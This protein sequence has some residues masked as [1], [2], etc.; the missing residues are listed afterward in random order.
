MVGASIWPSVEAS[1]VSP[2][3]VNPGDW[4][5]LGHDPHRSNATEQQVDPP[6]C[7]S[8]KWY[9]V[10]IASRIQPVVASGQLFIGSMNGLMYARDAT[11]GAPLWTYT[12][13]GPIRSTAGIS[14]DRLIFSSYDGF[15]YALATEDG[16]L[17]W[18]VNTG[19]SVTAPL[20]DESRGWV[21]VASSNGTLTALRL[22]D[23]Q[24]QWQSD[25]GAPI[26]TSP[27]LS[28]DGSTILTGNE[29]MYAL[30]Y[31]A[32][33]GSEL[34]RTPLSGQS[35]A[36]RYPVVAGSIVLYRS[37]PIG[38]FSE[39]LYEGDD[40]LD[41]AGAVDPNW[42]ADWNKVRPEILQ[43]LSSEPIKQ[44][45]FALDL[46][47]GHPA[48]LLPVLYTYGN[49][50]APSVP[51]VHADEVFLAY[52]PRHGIQTDGGS[53]HVS[54]RYDAELGWLNLSTMDIVG[55]TSAPSSTYHNQFRLTSDE[56]SML[57]MGGDILYVDNWERLGGI[58][59]ESGE[60]L[61]VGGV[62]DD[63]P[64]CGAQCGPGTTNPFFP[65]SGNP[66]D[67]A[68]PFPSMRVTEGDQR[69]GVVIANNMLYWRVIE[70]GLAG[71]SHTS[72]GSCSS[73]QVWTA[74][75]GTPSNDPYQPNPTPVE[76][77]ALED[78]LSIDMSVPA[79]N[80]PADLVARLQAEIRDMIQGD[81]HLLP[82][83]LMR[84]FSES[85]I[86]PYNTTNPPG[87]PK[88]T[89]L[90]HGNT[91]WQDPGE[92][93]YTMALAYPY[94]DSSLQSDLR[95]YMSGEMNRYPPL[96]NLSWYDLPWLKVGLPREYY[97]V[98]FRDELANWPP[99]DTNLS[100]LYSLWLWSK[101]TGD[102]SYVEA[103][104][105]Q[106]KALFEARRGSIRYYADLS[107]LIGYTRLAQQLGHTAEYQD[108]RQAALSAMQDAANY[109]LYQ[110]RAA[111]DYPDPRN[112]ETGWSLPELFGLTPEV[113]AFLRE[114]TDGKAATHIL[115]RENGNGVRWWYL[116]RAGDQAEVGET[117]YL[118]PDT[119]WSHFLAHAYVL[120][121]DSATLR[122][123]LDRSWALGDLYFIQK[124]VATI[125]VGGTTIE[126]GNGGK[127]HDLDLPAQSVAHYGRFDAHFQVDTPATDL[128][129]PYDDN[130]PAGLASEIGVTVDGLFTRDGWTTTITQP[131]FYDQPYQHDVIGGRDHFIPSGAPYF[132]VRFTPQTAGNWQFRIRVRDAE[133]VT[134]YPLQ[135]EAG[136]PFT[137]TASN[138]NPYLSRGFLNVSPTDSRYFEF[139]DGRL[140]SGVGFNDG[141]EQSADVENR[142]QAYEE[143]G[144]NFLRVW[145]SGD[146]INGSQWSS[147]A[148]HHLPNDNYLPGVLFDTN[149]TYNG[150]DVSLRID[151]SNPCYFSDF[152]QGGIPVA[153]STDY[154]VWARIKV[155][156]VTGP[157]TSGA[158]G[159]TIKQ[160]QWLGTDCDKG[161]NGTIITSHVN[162]SSDG[163]ITVEGSYHTGSN[164]AW[165]D[166][167][168]LA[169]E[170][171]TGGVVY[172][173]EVRV[174][175]EG[176]PAQVN[177]L[178]EP[179]ANSH[180][181]FDPMSSAQWD[182]FIESAEKHGVYLKLVIDEK[183][184][185]IRNHIAANGQM[186]SS[187][188]NDNFYA[189]S[190]TKVRWLEEAW[191]RYLIG[192]WGYSPAIH[193]FEYINEGDPYDGNH[194][195]AAN[196]MASFFDAH[197]PSRHMVTTSFWHSFPNIEFWSNPSYA[198]IDYA[199]LHAYIST[200]WGTTA[201]FLSSARLETW[202]ANV[203][204]GEA[205]AHFAGTDNGD[206]DIAPRGMVIQG[207][208]EWIIRYWMS[209]DNFTTNCPYSTTG[210]MQR[211]RWQVDGGNY[212]GGHEGVVPPNQEGKD[213]ICT[214]PAGTYTWTQFS[215]DRDRDGNQ[216]DASFRLILNDNNPHSLMI[217]IENSNGT[218]GDAWI[219]HVEIVNPNGEVVQV[220][221]EFITDRMDY[222]AAWYTAAYSEV[223]GGESPVG[224]RMPLVRG[225]TG[226]DTPDEQEW[227]PELTQDTQGIWLHNAV[228][229]QINAGGMY[230]LYW[231]A[232]ETIKPAFYKH[233]LT[234]Q[235]F[236]ADIP[237]NNGH[238]VRAE[239]ETSNP[240]LRAWGQRDDS[241][242]NMHLWIQNSQ[243]TW[244]R[245]VDGQSIPAVNGQVSIVAV[246][247]GTYQIEWWDTYASS[248]PIVLTET[249][250]A[251]GGTLALDLHSPLSSDIAVK[252]NRLS[253]NSATPTPVSTATPALPTPTATLT[254]TPTATALPS[255]TPTTLPSTATATPF[256]A[257]S[258]ATTVS[259]TTPTTASSS[260][261]ATSGTPTP[262]PS[263]TPTNSQPSP[264]ASGAMQGDL[265]VDDVVDIRDIQLW[266]N[267]FL[268]VETNP[269]LVSRADVNGDGSIN[270]IDVQTISNIILLG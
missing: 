196:A 177:I 201:S 233:F 44:T 190:G 35:L 221:G 15:T 91:Y 106:V 248:N 224:A 63:W 140:F 68:Y 57:S 87:V 144:I 54:T 192:R 127:I 171:A 1:S 50:D 209:A 80:P 49:N 130:P 191:W 222:D 167:L 36:D 70:G 48:G 33:S 52:R 220:I 107:G 122:S 168:Y 232:S 172:I 85:Q 95:Q 207:A 119:A 227:N 38:W 97:A 125:Q 83:Y 180:M 198:A 128:Y 256:V 84:G 183:N 263:S 223:F 210:G 165:L 65:L 7:Y 64:E 258:T 111:H 39:L 21:Y 181:Y 150:S 187:G 216:V 195:Q 164:Q 161:G 193:S 239:V 162:G 160:A 4:P 76:T 81:D 24:E 228:W 203:Y 72:S 120:Q 240:N 202:P 28:A 254:I 103:H 98:P 235:N 88:V 241:N 244:K 51:V 200:G 11:S 40:V 234:Y 186:T 82:M 77:R 13:N 154:H 266:I 67:P 53:V 123:W 138:P 18:K 245:I 90:D 163:W 215:S 37:Q 159:F 16:A 226:L 42:T 114:Q 170:N 260:P 155:D 133:G 213:F 179:N 176:D 151:N 109:A 218:G 253:G 135:S 132:S 134:Y 169:R 267:I 229:G 141:F 249:V 78:Y 27:T 175:R 262:G 105:N 74:T 112:M 137:V 246:P 206:Q 46:S 110:A 219:D 236:L 185:W 32:S 3:G 29:A 166:Y 188:S 131:A 45:I 231:W 152:W 104:W 55:L 99:P 20:V 69:G 174:W 199:D 116:T 115:S 94:L 214:S 47:T 73:P 10:P 158:Y 102:W 113:G 261:T 58:N 148:S 265:N 23:G 96:Q 189:Q 92:L 129:L 182:L 157:A 143:N 225:E 217:R 25:S 89:Y 100:V 118:A 270:V 8:W 211:V 9:E 75:P 101:N 59:T 208:G 62:S 147:W 6:Y 60:I 242:G 142:M 121:D 259:S 126:P 184:E 230:D 205:S 2:Q 136:I 139:D 93:L 71:I 269:E 238:Y 31:R 173:D 194:Y 255:A 153:S 5:Q 178:R 79:S 117:S 204:S 86:W 257:T 22:S 156:G 250:D 30:A 197:D 17:I 146:G 19:P 56:P 251:S 108:G 212:Y 145:L 14:N 41:R 34:W 237:L 26:L 124:L 12:T 264:T 43:Y 268:G 149:E 252:I 247:D 66:N 243:H 61:H